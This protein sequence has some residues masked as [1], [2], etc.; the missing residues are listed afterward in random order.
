MIK[1]M[2]LVL[3]SANIVSHTATVATSTEENG[4]GASVTINA[5]LEY[6]LRQN[7]ND[8]PIYV[9]FDDSYLH[10]VKVLC[11]IVV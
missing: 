4:E 10:R 7:I 3:I 5:M 1:K 9:M 11:H 8:M 6:L 2:M